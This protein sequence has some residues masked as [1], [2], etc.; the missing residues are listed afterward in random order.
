[1]FR[2]DVQCK[3]LGL[4]FQPGVD[5]DFCFEKFRDGAAGFGGF[6]GG[7][8]FGSVCARNARD[9]IKM[10]LRDSEAVRELFERNRSRRLEF[11][12]GQSGIAELRGERHGEAACMS[13]SQEIYWMGG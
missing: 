13:G 6:H 7:I 4:R 10:T 2:E 12:C 5:A 8:E 1:M 11:L 9:Q 3:R